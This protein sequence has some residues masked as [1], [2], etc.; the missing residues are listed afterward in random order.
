MNFA[1]QN[2]IKNDVQTLF[3]RTMKTVRTEEKKALYKA[4][5]AEGNGRVCP[6]LFRTLPY[7]VAYHH[8]GKVQVHFLKVKQIV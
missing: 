3:S 2:Q 1:L 6:I 8:S 7:G 4:L 5:C